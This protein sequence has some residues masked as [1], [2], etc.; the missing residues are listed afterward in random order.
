MNKQQ[1]AEQTEA[2]ETLREL[3]K[4]GDRIYTNLRKVSRSGM[5]RTISVHI[6]TADGIRDISSLVA[7]AA[8][9]RMDGW[10]GLKVGGCGMDMGFHVVYS[11]SSVLFRDDFR[12]T[13]HDGSKRA[14]R[15]PSNDHSNYRPW[16]EQGTYNR[17]THE[18]EG[19]IDNPQKNFSRGRKHS[20]GGYALSHVWL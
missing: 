1:K 3:V 16:I 10:D 20:D 11:L 7:R 5:S 18:W 17:E 12:C 15:C 8:G 2:I 9:Y 14:N 13:G 4:P 19:R 6:K